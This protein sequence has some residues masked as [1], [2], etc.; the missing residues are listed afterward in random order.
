MTNW[1]N[2]DGL[3]V[4]FGLDAARL[5]EVSS[6]NELEQHVSVVIN[7]TALALAGGRVDSDNPVVIPAGSYITRAFF[8]VITAFT[9]AGAATLDLGLGLADGTYTGGDED[10]IDVAIALS[11]INAAGL[12][13]VCNGALVGGTA[14]SGAVDLYPT[15]DVDTA[16]YTAGKGVLHIAYIPPAVPA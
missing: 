2:A 12:V 11:A 13:V 5:G 4:K 8:R 16:V 3:E 10:G 7:A 1:T 14:I 15:Y 6:S 9:S